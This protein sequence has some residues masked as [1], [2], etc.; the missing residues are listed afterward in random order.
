M[1]VMTI[2]DENFK[3]DVLGSDKP[4]LLDFWAEWC[5]PCKQ[6]A[7]AL[8]ELATELAGSAIIGK[9]NIE[10]SPNTPVDF[11]VRGVP[12]LMVFK[13][14]EVVATRT[15]AMTKSKLAEWLAEFV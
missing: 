7:P 13:G 2:T 1:S 3:A 5:G 15:G 11:H 8:D 14:G 12:T 9:M 10:D 6:M 4:V